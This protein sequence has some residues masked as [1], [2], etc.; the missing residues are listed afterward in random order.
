MQ[1][2]DLS[3]VFRPFNAVYV[4]LY[5]DLLSYL[6]RNLVFSGRYIFNDV[7]K[8]SQRESTIQTAFG[9]SISRE[10]RFFASAYIGPACGKCYLFGYFL[11]EIL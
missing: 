11:T 9:L 5:P 2:Y 7:I 3:F 8:E 4:T 10:I 1:I 6:R